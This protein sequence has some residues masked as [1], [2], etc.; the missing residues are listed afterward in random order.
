MRKPAVY[1]NT[2]KKYTYSIWRN[3]EFN[4]VK[5]GGTGDYYHGLKGQKITIFLVCLITS[6]N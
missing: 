4:D 6:E 1:S 2:R 5:V 3:A